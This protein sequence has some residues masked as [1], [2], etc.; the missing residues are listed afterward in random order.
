MTGSPLPVDVE[1]LTPAW[2]SA[3]LHRDVLEVIVVERTTGTTGRARVELRLD[4]GAT[5]P[6]FVKLPPFGD[7]QRALV[8]RTG[9]GVTEARFYRDLAEEMPIRVPG[10]WF[11]AT[12]GHDYV[13][14]LEDLVASGCRFPSPSDEDIASRARDIVEELARLH[15]SYWESP[16]FAPGGDLEWLAE[17]GAR[18]GAGGRRF[19][20]HAV[21]VLGDRAG[22]D[23]R[24]I[25]EVYLAHSDEIVELWRAGP[26]TLVHGDSHIGN[27]FVDQADD[28]T[29]FLDWAVVGRA[30]GIRDVAYVLCNSVPPDVRTSIERGLIE[31]YCDLLSDAGVALAPEQAW[32]Q[33]R[34]HAV[35][36]WVAA[37]ATA[38]MGSK[39]QPIEVGLG[40][41]R[42]A[43]A[44]CTELGSADLLESV[45]R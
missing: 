31:R 42:R 37:A 8:N 21:D 22:D 11:A 14:L 10:A 16:R 43:T 12:A 33:Y 26:S 1:D 19:I 24:R 25:A 44:A 41:T 7:D 29:G 20:Q 34:I 6:V 2:F 28:R 36:S 30:P 23:F 17:R 9:M 35:Y 13:M 38:G 3:A 40:G 4:S 5:R 39:W 27:L 32:D 45:L 18:G 15:S